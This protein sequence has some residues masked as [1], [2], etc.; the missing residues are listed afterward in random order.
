M[1]NATFA[2]QLAAI[3]A[4]AATPTTPKSTIFDELLALLQQV[5]ANLPQLMAIIAS[6][7]A[8]F[9]GKLPPLP[10]LPTVKG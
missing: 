5:A 4:R 3:H 9:G 2:A 1:D 6:I 10:A 7:L 8:L